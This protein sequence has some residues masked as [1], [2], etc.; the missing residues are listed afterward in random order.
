M[1]AQAIVRSAAAGSAL[2]SLHAAVNALL[3]RRPPAAA[4]VGERVSVLLPLRNEAAR[5]RPC[6]EAV[7]HQRHLPDIEVLV[8]DDGSTDGTADVVRAMGL[9]PM[10]GAALPAGWRG[11]PHACQ[12]LA[13]AADGSVLVFVDADVVLAADA[14]SR[15]V[16]LL[17]ETDLQL[18]SPYPRQVARSVAE[19]LV[20]PL[21]QWS[22][23]TFLPLRAAE[24]SSRSSLAAANGQLLVVDAQAYRR[25]G[26]HTAV[27]GE[28]VEDMALARSMRQHG[29]RGGFADGGELASCRMYDGFADLRDGYTKSLWAAFGSPAG[30]A[31]VNTLLL[32]LYVV[33]PVAALR[34]SRAGAVGYAVAVAG[35]VV[36]ARRTGGRAWPDAAAHPLSVL[37]LTALTVRSLHHRATGRLQWKGRAL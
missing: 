35:R 36:S 15:A 6:L 5:V 21:L 32:W 24:R 23:L 30:A 16:R 10:A 28:V 8:L 25:S 20:Q 9:Q 18:V 1:K 2:L 22:W 13:D 3:L 14:V 29:A 34:R 12:Q 7:L 19:R 27:R 4:T 11:K 37:A 17:R 31:A 33:P 26:G